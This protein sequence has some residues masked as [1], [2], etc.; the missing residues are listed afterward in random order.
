MAINNERWDE[1]LVAKIVG[2]ESDDD[3]VDEGGLY[4]DSFR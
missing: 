2:D 4:S 1:E 3:F